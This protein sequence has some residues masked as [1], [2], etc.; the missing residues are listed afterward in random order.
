MDRI[1]VGILC[2][3]ILYPTVYES[4]DVS[5]AI[6]RL[7]TE[8]GWVVWAE[9]PALSPS[10]R[11]VYGVL[12]NWDIPS[13]E[14]LSSWY[15]HPTN[16]CAEISATQKR[17]SSRYKKRAIRFHQ[18]PTEQQGLCEGDW[19]DLKFRGAASSLFASCHQLDWRVF[20][21]L[22]SK[23]E[24]HKVAQSRQHFCR[25]NKAVFTTQTWVFTFRK[26]VV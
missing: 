7:S 14:C 12:M 13:V 4:L 21:T 24:H 2:D 18:N 10:I 9:F 20:E 25:Q 3:L 5:L 23:M 6:T 11:E 15:I 19:L 26:Q 22:K 1:I 16:N 17:V 8:I